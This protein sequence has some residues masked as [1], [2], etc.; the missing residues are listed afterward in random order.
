VGWLV[1]VGL[2]VLFHFG[3]LWTL[4]LIGIAGGGIMCG[5]LICSLVVI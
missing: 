4:V 5:G 2:G 1:C 3:C